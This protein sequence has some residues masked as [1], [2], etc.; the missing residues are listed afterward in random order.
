MIIVTKTE[1][2]FCGNEAKRLVKCKCPLWQ[3][4]SHDILYITDSKLIHL[5][6]Q[7]NEGHDKEGRM[8]REKKREETKEE[9]REC[10]YITS[11]NMYLVKYFPSI[12]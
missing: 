8:E 6:S 4:Y 11:V 10:H 9:R 5:S 12:C 2:F 7:T 3:M 1:V